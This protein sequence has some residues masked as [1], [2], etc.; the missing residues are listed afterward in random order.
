MRQLIQLAHGYCAL[1][2]DSL[3]SMTPPPPHPK[4]F[5]PNVQPLEWV[6]D[7]PQWHS[8]QL[9]DG[10]GGGGKSALNPV[11]V[12]MLLVAETKP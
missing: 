5:L 4:S 1:V 3:G 10:G 11:L 6:V 2:P 7:N 12:R 8:V 9:L